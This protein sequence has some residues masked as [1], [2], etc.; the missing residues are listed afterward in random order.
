MG[1]IGGSDGYTGRPGG[2]YPGYQE[3]RY[4]KGGYCGLYAD[5]LTLDGVLE[6]LRARRAYGTT[7]ARIYVNL[8]ADGNPIGARYHT[9]TPSTILAAVAGT[10]PLERVVLYRGLEKVYEHPFQLKRAAKRVRILWEG[11]SRRTS[12][13]GVV[14]DG[15]LGVKGG[16]I[17]V[18]DRVRFDSPRSHLYE[19]GDCGLRWH[20]VTCG[21]R[22]G[23]LLDLEGEAEGE[24]SCSVVVDNSLITMA[25]YGGFGDV[26]PKRVSYGPTQTLQFTFTLSELS[27]GPKVIEIGPLN[28]RITV[29]LAPE[30]DARDVAFAW[31]D[32]APV[33]GINPYW[34]YV[35][36]AD[37]EMAWTSPIF[38]DCVV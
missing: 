28:R 4:S 18:A 8:Q 10:A 34:L 31:T 14:W 11:A 35:E 30:S 12:Y 16:T 3:R 37:M 15:S 32:P 9:K 19:V 22:S 20:S 27:D 5:E 2:E 26:G 24:T 1:F 36:Q 13:S 7:G 33:P 25:A 17:A 23:V 21:Y 6:A 29:E 38:A